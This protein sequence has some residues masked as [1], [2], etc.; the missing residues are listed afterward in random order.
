MALLLRA[1]LF[2][3]AATL[4]LAQPSIDWQTATD[5][6]G[7]DMQGLSPNQK[8]AVLKILREQGCSCTC[9]MRIAECRI[10]DPR[11]GFST[12]LAE[13]VVKAVREGKN[14]D[15]VL[16]DLKAS[17]LSKGPPERKILEDPVKT[18]IPTAGAP[19]KG[20]ADARITLIEFSDFECPYCSRAVHQ[21]DALLKAYPTEIRLIYKQF[22]LSMHPHARMAATAALAA[23]E[24]GKFWEMHD[25]LFANYRQLSRERILALAKDAGLD[26]DR[27]TADWTSGKFD[28]AVS[29]DYKDGETAG[30]FG[31][32]AF[33]INGKLYNGPMELAAVKPLIDAELKPVRASK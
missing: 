32:P 28:A 14:M 12:G 3:A 27:F 21:V 6:P 8:T 17:P 30:V 31:T 19:L 24:Q 11:C 15:Q 20:P 23:N 22:P 10:K 4:L 26:M 18:P 5:L 33:F 1:C 13:V 2:T 25:R 16:D 9:G 7:V 29:A